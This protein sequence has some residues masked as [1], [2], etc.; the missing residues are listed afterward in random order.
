MSYISQRGIHGMTSQLSNLILKAGIACGESSQNTQKHTA[1][2]K[3][4]ISK[5]HSILQC[6]FNLQYKHNRMREKD[7]IRKL[8]QNY[9]FLT[10]E[11]A[12]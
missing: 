7:E 12:K 3:Q 4:R 2:F 11:I 1:L 5:N 8:S 10:P 9:D 6:L